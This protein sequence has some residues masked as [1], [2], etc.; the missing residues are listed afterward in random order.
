MAAKIKRKMVMSIRNEKLQREPAG[1]RCVG[2]I[3]VVDGGAAAVKDKGESNLSEG[4]LAGG[5]II[6]KEL[7]VAAPLDSGFELTAG[8]VFAE[9]LVQQVAEEFVGK[10]AI[11][12]GL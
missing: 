5:G 2:G 11:G 1:R 9:M 3:G 8:F 12:F 10:R 4:Q 7:G 6:V